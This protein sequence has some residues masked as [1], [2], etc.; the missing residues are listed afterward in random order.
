MSPWDVLVPA[1]GGDAVLRRRVEQAMAPRLR[2]LR[3]KLPLGRGVPFSG[4]R[5]H[6]WIHATEEALSLGE[7]RGSD[8]VAQVAEL[9]LLAELA[10]G[11]KIPR[12]FAARAARVARAQLRKQLEEWNLPDR[13]RRDDLDL[14]LCAGDPPL[15]VGLSIGRV[16]T[17]RG[18]NVRIGSA[19]A[20]FEKNVVR[21]LDFLG[22][23]WP[24]AVQMVLGRTWRVVPVEEKAIVSYSSAVRPGIT[25]IQRSL[26]RGRGTTGAMHLAE[27]LLHEGTHQRVHDL[28][29]LA[30][31]APSD[32]D[33]PRF[34]SPWRREWRPLRGLLHG[35]CTFTVGA[36]YFARVLRALEEQGLV[37]DPALRPWLTRRF[38]EEM[39]NVRTALRFLQRAQ[40]PRAGKRLLKTVEREHAAL[41]AEGR[42][43]RADLSPGERATVEAHA[44]ELRAQPLRWG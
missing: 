4:G 18:T 11:G 29:V 42:R 2:S 16:V 1:R 27:H 7:A 43:R 13:V 39:E 28:E 33:G 9:G 37:L 26:G 41:R 24:D 3:R 6:G 23:V 44:R 22:A 12:A 35:A 8:L 25:W 15:P 10:P 40:L 19:D 21:A 36:G 32:E 20:R 38:L 34:Y 17:T 14:G 30:P 31:I 5:L